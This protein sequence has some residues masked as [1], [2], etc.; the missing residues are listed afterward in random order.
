MC[1]LSPVPLPSART[2]MLE[3]TGVLPGQER[4]TGPIGVLTEREWQLLERVGA[5]YSNR[6]IGQQQC[7]RTPRQQAKRCP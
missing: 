5:G 3:A 4:A 7:H 2:L 6:E 1:E